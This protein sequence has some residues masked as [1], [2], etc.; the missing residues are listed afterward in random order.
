MSRLYDALAKGPLEVVDSRLHQRVA[1]SVGSAPSRAP[2]HFVPP[3]TNLPI[4]ELSVPMDEPRGEEASLAI[5]PSEDLRLV[6]ITDPDGI[7]AEKF[8]ALVTRLNHIREEGELKALQVTSSVMNE[9]KT[10]V[11][12]NLAVTLAMYSGAKTLLVEGD[13][14]R[15]RLTTRFG[16]GKLDGLNDW[17]LAP[18]KD[19]AQFTYHLKGMPLWILPAGTLCNQPSHILQSTRFANSF[20]QL[21]QQFEWVIV[22]STPMLPV[23]DANL[24]SGVVDGSIIV[25]RENM[26]PVGALKK[27]L[28]AMDRPKL[29]G[30]VINE[31]LPF[32]RDRGEEQYYSGIPRV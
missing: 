6:S 25:V 1:P 11:S 21:V 3:E 5:W 31:R 22:D 2:V 4:E 26:V 13:L 12:A 9:G 30:M 20:A 15:P 18:K 16:L 10:V 23:V 32:N 8:R 28:E 19:L 7:G 29:V 14:R 17:Y 27:G 24:W